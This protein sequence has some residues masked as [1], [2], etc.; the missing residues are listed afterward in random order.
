MPVHGILT[1]ELLGLAATVLLVVLALHLTF[2][3]FRLVGIQPLEVVLLLFVSPFLAAVN[4]PVWREPGVVFGLNLAGAGVPV[5]LSYRFLR[6]RRL[7]AWKGVVGAAAMTGLAFKVAEV[8]PGEGVLVPPLPLVV[9]SAFV[10][11]LLAGRSWHQ[12]GPATYV[13]GALG[14]L[15]GADLLNIDAF[16]DPAREEAVFMVVGG[17]GTLDA[18][19][20]ISLYAVVATIAAALVAK[21]LGGG[22]EG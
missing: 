8:A 21:V 11:A 3:G 9:A 10:G 6:S 12:V 13:S 14:T 4:V 5:Y 18:I 2:S 20:L 17:A 22:P 15:V 19:F 7:P 1:P 16:V